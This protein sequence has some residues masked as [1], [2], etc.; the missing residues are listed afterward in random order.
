LVVLGPLGDLSPDEL[1]AYLHRVAD[2]VADYR[3]SIESRPISPS[4]RPGGIAALL[5]STMPERAE[6]LDRILAELDRVVMP[7]IVHWGHPSF[8][9]YFGSTSN[10]PA[11]L[12]EIAAAALNVSAMTWR[13]SPAATELET[14][15]VEWIRQVIGLPEEF[16]GVVYDTASVGVVHALAAARERVAASVRASGLIGRA[17][18]PILRVYASDQAHSS[19]AK[20]MVI[21]GLGETNL[22][23]VPSDD[24]FRLDVDALR[25]AMAA[26][27]KDG[28]RPMA[29]VATVGTTSTAS[30][31]PVRA[32]ADLCR[33]HDA[34]LHVDAAY[35]GAMA[36]MPEAQRVMDAV[37][38]ADSVIVNPHKWLFVPL[39][40]SVLYTR[41]RALLRSV[42]ALTPEYLRGDAAG[43][44]AI[45]YMDYGIQLGRRFRSLKA[46]MVLRAMGRDGIA[47][48]IREHCR[49]ARHFATLVDAAPGF[50]TVAPVSMGVVC[51]RYAPNESADA[52]AIDVL[53]ET[54]VARVNASGDAYI[55]HTRLRGRSAMRVG[56]GNIATTQ[57]HVERVWERVR[58]EALATASSDWTTA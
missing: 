3:Q 21:L 54:I 44:D 10:G 36:V 2:W 41:H 19:I 27:V 56:I 52:E 26:D 7:G 46:W 1:R 12:G 48:R 47:S 16:F 39:D 6:P 53:N 43:T 4:I 28:H 13:T 55:T 14:V 29:V 30:V 20:A 40:F 31:D 17:E 50:R 32:I 45:D 34:W 23:R 18:L 35:G 42:F 9:G 49:L 15:V 24:A 51:F 11:L 57:H 38:L 22:V 25:A 37:E 8:L 58:A 5:G 33:A